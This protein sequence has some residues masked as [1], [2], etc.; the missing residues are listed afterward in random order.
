MRT[1]LT[2]D[3]DLAARIARLQRDRAVPLRVVINDAL[4]RGL[5]ALEEGEDEAPSTFRTP[6]W[7]GQPRLPSLDDVSEVLA[8]AEG[9]DFA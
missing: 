1:T 4:R 6:T 8:H 5:P 9:D 2:I 7:I 3:E